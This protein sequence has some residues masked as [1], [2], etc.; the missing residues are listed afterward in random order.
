MWFPEATDKEVRDA[1]EQADALI[2]NSYAEGLGLPILE[3]QRSEL[4][5]IARDL[6]VF[7]ET[8][9]PSDVLV[10]APHSRESLASTVRR[11]VH[12]TRGSYRR[13]KC[14]TSTAS[15]SD[16]AQTLERVLINQ[17]G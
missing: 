3:D 12:E 4:P 11:F 13:S 15:W 1:L 6:G 16:T 7:R 2:M 8:I 9:G 17:R 10:P 14:F 5:V